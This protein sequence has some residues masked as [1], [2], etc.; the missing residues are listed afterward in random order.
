MKFQLQKTLKSE[1]LKAKK[2]NFFCKTLSNLAPTPWVSGIIWKAPT[3]CVK[4][5]DKLSENVTI[6]G[7]ILSTFESSII[8]EAWGSFGQEWKSA[9]NSAWKFICFKSVNFL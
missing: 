5:L 7:S 1:F 2:K 4:D 6:F 3:E 8:F 9:R